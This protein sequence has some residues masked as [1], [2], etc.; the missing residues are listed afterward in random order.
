MKRETD[1]ASPE[2][3]ALLDFIKFEC[4]RYEKAKSEEEAKR[5]AEFLLTAARALNEMRE[6]C[7]FA[8]ELDRR[9]K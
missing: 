1:R 4:E 6:D 2:R 8:R 7:F 5:A 3:A 9:K